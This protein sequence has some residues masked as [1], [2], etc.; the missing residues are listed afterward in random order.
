M[1]NRTFQSSQENVSP[2]A[3]SCCFFAH[4]VLNNILYVLKIVDISNKKR[5]FAVANK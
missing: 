1:C 3:F 4:K 2:D 5:N